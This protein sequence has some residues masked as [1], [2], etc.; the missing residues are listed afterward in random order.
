MVHI[1]SCLSA[2]PGSGPWGRLTLH[3]RKDGEHADL[4]VGDRI[5]TS[6]ARLQLHHPQPSACA[7]SS[8]GE[9]AEPHG[10]HHLHI[11]GGRAWEEPQWNCSCPSAHP[12]STKPHRWYPA[13][14]QSGPTQVVSHPGQMAEGEWVGRGYKWGEKQMKGERKMGIKATVSKR[15][16]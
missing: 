1:S 4:C 7:R 10:K 2:L 16:L 6:H 3:F 8:W 12:P 9:A 11:E 14:P 13:L 5:S 15:L